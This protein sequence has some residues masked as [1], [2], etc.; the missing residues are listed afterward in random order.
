MAHSVGVLFGILAALT[1]NSKTEFS[2]WVAAGARAGV[3]RRLAG[4]ARAGSLSSRI[5]FLGYRCNGFLAPHDASVE[6]HKTV[7]SFWGGM[8]EGLRVEDNRFCFRMSFR[9]FFQCYPSRPPRRGL[10]PR[11]KG[12]PSPGGPLRIAGWP[13][14]WRACHAR[15]PGPK[16]HSN[17]NCLYGF[18][19]VPKGTPKGMP[20][21][22][23][24]LTEGLPK[25]S[26]GRSKFPGTPNSLALQRV[27][28]RWSQPKACLMLFY[29][30]AANQT[31][32]VGLGPES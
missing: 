7:N 20:V 32:R 3:A 14:P 16:G 8:L 12:S 13:L 31:T 24:G 10:G 1:A 6:M 4:R 27:M 11:A 23:A 22:P 19:R 28:G 21:T 15:W 2:V 30:T 17:I 18:Q 26:Q 9:E 25:G 29:T 5:V